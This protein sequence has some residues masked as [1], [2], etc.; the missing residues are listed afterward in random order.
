MTPEPKK[1]CR[2]DSGKAPVL[3]RF[4][5]DRPNDSRK[6][7]DHLD[8]YADP[9]KTEVRWDGQTALSV[10]PCQPSAAVRNRPQG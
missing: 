8:N 10:P 9:L 7:F 1:P 6:D 2:N 4:R 3:T 5:S